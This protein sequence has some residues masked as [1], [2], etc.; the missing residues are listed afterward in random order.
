MER[1][2]E[3]LPY[4][5]AVVPRSGSRRNPATASR[6][7]LQ[8]P[9]GWVNDTDRAIC[10]LRSTEDLQGNTMK[11][12]KRV[13]HL[14]VR[15]IRAQGIVGAGAG[16]RMCTSPCAGSTAKAG[17]SA[18]R[19]SSC[20]HRKVRARVCSRTGS[21]DH[22]VQRGIADLIH[23]PPLCFQGLRFGAVTQLLGA[24]HACSPCVPAFCHNV[25]HLVG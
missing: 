23:F 9:P 16:I 25:V 15:A 5:V 3:E 6:Q 21:R 4:S 12:V 11:R 13:E 20:S 19:E 14:Y 18:C 1:E 22:S 8:S 7:D 2:I 17:R 10:P 24:S